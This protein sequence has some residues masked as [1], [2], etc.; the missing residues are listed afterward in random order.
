[1]GKLTDWCSFSLLAVDLL[2][3]PLSFPIGVGCCSLCHL[4]STTVSSQL[5]FLLVHLSPSQ[6]S[7]NSDCCC[8]LDEEY[9][10]QSSS[11]DCELAGTAYTLCTVDASSPQNNLLLAGL[12]LAYLSWQ[13]ALVF[14]G[15]LWVSLAFLCEAPQCCLK[16]S[17]LSRHCTSPCGFSFL[18]ALLKLP[19]IP[20]TPLHPPSGCPTPKICTEPS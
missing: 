16:L 20:L 5:P 19:N 14:A 15:P 2:L 13:D 7:R 6:L 4:L 17:W 1:M 3:S 12:L 9:Y 18:Q 11:S 8:S 10:W